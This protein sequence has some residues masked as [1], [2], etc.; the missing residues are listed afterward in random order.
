VPSIEERMVYFYDDDYDPCQAQENPSSVRKPARSLVPPLEDRMVYF[1]DPLPE[2]DGAAPNDDSD[3]DNNNKNNKKKSL[4][5]PLEERMVYFYEELQGH[6]GASRKEGQAAEVT[7]Q[8]LM[9]YHGLIL[10]WALTPI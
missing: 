1:Y 8:H 3:H 6:Q 2:D 7:I 5:P 9:S 4:V 10:H